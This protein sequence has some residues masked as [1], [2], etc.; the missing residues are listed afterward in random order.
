MIK[1]SKGHGTISFP[2]WWLRLFCMVICM[3]PCY[4]PGGPSGKESACQ[5]RR[6]KR[7]RCNPWV[8]KI[9]WRRPCQPTPVFLPG[10]SHRQRSL[11]VYSPW[12]CKESDM[13]ESDLS[14]HSL[15]CVNLTSE[16]SR[17]SHAIILVDVFWA[18]TYDIF[19]ELLWPVFSLTVI[20]KKI[21]YLHAP[22]MW[23]QLQVWWTSVYYIF[24]QHIGK[25][26]GKAKDGIPW[27]VIGGVLW[28]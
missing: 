15:S 6:H 2:H 27:F 1:I 26:V 11:A 3:V 12:G 18:P 25:I 24:S 4:F 13:T 8:P 10:K 20:F 23:I 5:F 21:C 28:V 7:C 16:G 22:N 14:S 17:S 9:P 19:R